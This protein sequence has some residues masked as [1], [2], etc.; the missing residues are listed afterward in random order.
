[1]NTVI[2]HS[3][4]DR[5]FIVGLSFTA[6]VDQI[7]QE[8]GKENPEAAGIAVGIAIGF[9][10]FVALIA[11]LFGWMSRKRWLPV[12]GIGI[13]VYILDGLLYLLLGDY[14]SAGFHAFAGWSMISG[15]NAY[16]NLRKLELALESAADPDA[17]DADDEPQVGF[18][19]AT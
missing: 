15:F 7:A 3:G 16:R 6:I 5:H 19:A 2:A 13:G 12:Y 17:V 18:D 14:F 1:V 10:C 4:G 11:A 8:I 9:S